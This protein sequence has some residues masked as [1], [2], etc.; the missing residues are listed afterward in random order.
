[1]KL[2]NILTIVNY[3]RQN[4]K[5][6]LVCIYICTLLII[7]LFAV[8]VSANEPPT[9]PDI[10]GPTSGKKGDVLEYTF[11]STDPDGDDI[12]YCINWGCGDPEICI[13]PFPS[14]E[15]QVSSHTYGV[16]DYTI[17]IKALD[18]NGAETEWKTLD[19]SVPKIKTFNTPFLTFLE[20]HPHLFT[21][22]RQILG[23]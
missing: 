6:K 5:K 1:M 2:Y 17:Q 11:V 12:S 23:L 15:E 19:I 20:N 14:G 22:L 3:W 9:I 7:P 21:L 4:M 10:T 8:T 18:T 13:G 16:G